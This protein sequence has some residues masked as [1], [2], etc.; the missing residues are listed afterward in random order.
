[1]AI[2]LTN[3]E[4]TATYQL[5]NGA[6]NSGAAAIGVGTSFNYSNQTAAGTYT[7]VATNADNGCTANMTGNAVITI[8]PT[9]TPSVSIVSDDADN[10]IN[11]GTSVTF[12]ASQT[13]GGTTPQYQWQKNGANVGANDPS[14]TNATLANNDVIR[15]ILTSNETCPS[16][17]TATSNEITMSVSG[18]LPIELRDF[19]GT[20]QYNGNLLTW[21]TANEVN[22]KGFYVERNNGITDKWDIIGFVNT[23]CRDKACLVSTTMVMYDFTDNIPLN[24]SYYRLRQIDNDG[25]ETLSK[26]ISI[27]TKENNKLKVYPNPV[28]N[29]LTVETTG[30][31]DYHVFNLLG[32]QVLSGQIPPL[33]AR[34]LDVS[35]LPQGTYFLKVGAEQVKFIKQ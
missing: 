19:K 15:V 14:Y 10:S 29:V 25:K 6:S 30:T 21:T 31:V 4:T 13:N 24:T 7:V 32:Q 23:Q 5:K 12:T 22:N 18:V 28:S 11:A 27:S 9:V 1:V 35:A 20:P 34:G 2:G 16:T 33:G 26:V 17:P 8:T 3:S